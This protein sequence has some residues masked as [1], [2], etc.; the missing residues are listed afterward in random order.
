MQW[1]LGGGA[2][3]LG[4]GALAVALTTSAWAWLLVPPAALGAARV[5]RRGR[6]RLQLFD[7]HLRLTGPRPLELAYADVTTSRSERP[8]AR[9]CRGGRRPRP[10][11]QPRTLVLERGADAPALRLCSLALANPDVLTALDARLRGAPEPVA[12]DRRV[13]VGLAVLLVTSL[14][15]AAIGLWIVWLRLG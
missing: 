11:E 4:V 3:L 1:M 7:D 9:D 14:V 10:G 8:T 2:A 13:R 6:W 15:V 12:S 5:F